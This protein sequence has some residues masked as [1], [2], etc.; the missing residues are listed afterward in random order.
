M[1]C[2]FLLL[3]LYCVFEYLYCCG[4]AYCIAQQSVYIALVEG[5]AFVAVC[6]AVCADEKVVCV[7]AV[8][9]ISYFY[10]CVFHSG[11]DLE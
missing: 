11:S 4:N 2:S 8:Y 1:S 6:Y 3:H 10:Y 7:D 5:V 9:H